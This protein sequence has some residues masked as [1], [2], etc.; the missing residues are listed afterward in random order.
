MHILKKIFTTSL[1]MHLSMFMI[2]HILSSKK[3]ASKE[4]S[5]DEGDR[6]KEL[7]KRVTDLKKKLYNSGIINKIVK[8]DLDDK[9][10]G[11]TLYEKGKFY[12]K[13]KT[14]IV[15]A[16]NSQFSTGG[17]RL[18]KAVTDFVK[19]KN[20]V[21]NGEW[22]H[23][24]EIECDNEDYSGRIGV[25]EFDYGYVLHIVGLNAKDL[26]DGNIP[27]GKVEDYIYKLYKYAFIGIKEILEGREKESEEES[28]QESEEESEGN[29][30][31]NVL[32]CFVSNG[33]YACS[34]ED[35]DGTKFSGN[36]FALRAQIGCLK[37]IKKYSKGLNIVLNSR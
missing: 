29:D 37:A 14:V 10:M 35:K 5:E 19:S 17:G 8:M 16:A 27:I 32:V 2:H 15:N 25:S 31:G 11:I 34:D 23:L 36:E 20:G 33:I 30:L 21:K 12:E 28:E 24:R 22:K 3:K 7:Q 9:I 6:G 13:G 4:L 18:N 1:F 26:K